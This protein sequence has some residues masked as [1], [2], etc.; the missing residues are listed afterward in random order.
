MLGSAPLDA[1]IGIVL[2][3][4][5]LSAICSA[6][7]EWILSALSTREKMMFETMAS[8][9]SSNFPSDKTKPKAKTPADILSLF[10]EHPAIKSHASKTRG[11]VGWLY[12]LLTCFFRWSLSKFRKSQKTENEQK[13]EEMLLLNQIPDS[14]T[15]EMFACA[16]IS[17]KHENNDIDNLI[18]KLSC[19]SPNKPESILVAVYD[20]VMA[21]ATNTYKARSRVTTFW[22]GLILAAALNIDSVANFKYFLN[23]P[24]AREAVVI[25]AMELSSPSTQPEAK[26][27][28]EAADQDSKESP[29]SKK[30][31]AE[32]Q[33]LE[34]AKEINN[35]IIAKYGFPLGWENG[36]ADWSSRKGMERLYWVCMKIMGIFATAFAAS[37]GSQYWFDIMRNLTTLRGALQKDKSKKKEEGNETEE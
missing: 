32:K 2:I 28:T 25:K 17:L 35:E 22:I 10:F 20:Q 36:P 7:V 14:F 24:S 6:I 16:M 15:G 29:C 33:G 5:V 19:D 3:F 21:K 13:I 1:L 18:K 8:L 26:S 9:F 4:I 34:M 37:L 31:A 27:K 23:N 30:M 12:M 11:L